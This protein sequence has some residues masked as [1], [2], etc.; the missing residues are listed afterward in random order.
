[1]TKRSNLISR[2]AALLPALLLALLLTAAPLPPAQAAEELPFLDVRE[3]GYYR[4]PLSWAWEEGII[5][6]TDEQH[7]SPHRALRLSELAAF[8]YRYAYSP[9]PHYSQPALEACRERWYYQALSWCCD[10]GIVEPFRV[11]GVH[12]PSDLLTRDDAVKILYRYVVRWEKQSLS[13]DPDC[14]LPFADAPGGRADRAAWS[15]AVSAGVVSGTDSKHLSPG[16]HVTRAQFITM[17][18]GLATHPEPLRGEEL[19]G[20][21]LRGWQRS[22]A[23]A[24]ELAYGASW[25]DAAYDLG[26]D[27]IPTRIDCS[28]FVNWC[29]RYSGILTY[30]DMDCK[31]IWNSDTFT[32]LD[33]KR[34]VE[35]GSEFLLRSLEKLKPGDLF[36]NH[37]STTGDHM[38][39]FLGADKRYLYVLHCRVGPGV[40]AEAVPISEDSSYI[41]KI[42]GIMRYEP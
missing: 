33:E 24:G 27:G 20:H 9:T 30:E 6:G 13:P 1:M 11:T 19:T 21:R 5:T 29:F 4:E 17:L 12:K 34:S 7:V 25:V 14:L 16:M 28:G 18:Y 38:M 3:L 32:R 40:R 39:I 8:L 2:A 42:R 22:L 10:F 37:N 36:Y 31:A 23:A 15:W 35:S 41:R 26:P